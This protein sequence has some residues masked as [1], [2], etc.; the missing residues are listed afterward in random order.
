M[1]RARESR[2]DRSG[3]RQHRRQLEVQRRI[4][5]SALASPQCALIGQ[6]PVFGQSA[7]MFLPNHLVHTASVPSASSSSTASFPS[8]SSVLLSI[9]VFS[10]VR[11]DS[12]AR[13]SSFHNSNSMSALPPYLD[14][15]SHLCTNGRA[16][17]RYRNCHWL[18][19]PDGEA[20]PQRVIIPLVSLRW[21][22][23]CSSVHEISNCSIN[24][25]YGGHIKRHEMFPMIRLKYL[26]S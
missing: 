3:R 22:L 23:A 12:S 19:W 18:Q 26:R 15:S 9:S 6:C 8:L 10:Y 4:S 17:H 11:S 25:E 2:S 20:K 14:T 24:A 5:A 16:R 7:T 21:K 1:L 13:P